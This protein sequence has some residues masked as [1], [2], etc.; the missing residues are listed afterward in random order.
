MK[1]RKIITAILTMCI[2][3]TLVGVVPSRVYAASTTLKVDGS[4]LIKGA[5]NCVTVNLKNNDMKIAGLEFFISFDTNAYSV[6]E[7]TSSLSGDWELDWKQK[8]D[9]NYGNGIHCMIQDASLKGIS[10]RN[11]EVIKII[12]QDKNTQVGQNYDFNI[13]IIDISDESGNHIASKATSENVR[14]QCVSGQEINISSYVNIE[15]FQISH[16]IGGFRTVASVEPQ[17]DG[18][19]V[20][21]Y[22]NIYAIVRAGVSENDMYI[23]S[24]SSYVASYKATSAGVIDT[25]YSNSQTAVNYV[26]TMSN[27]GTTKEALNQ[28]YMVRAYAKLANGNYVYSNVESY[29][30]YNV[31]KVLYDNSVMLTN[32]GHEYLYNN[33]LKVVDSNYKEVPYN[34]SNEV[35]KPE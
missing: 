15:G 18:Q 2:M 1:G 13:D 11:Q 35:A 19:Q 32:V 16:S 4:Q 8:N 28:E 3:L 22:G 26:R 7:V 5:S 33:I 25:N 12:L 31:A 29:S 10:D 27:N 17:I 14:L 30:I 34:W 23:G 20:V 21:E 24:T 6:T 9:A